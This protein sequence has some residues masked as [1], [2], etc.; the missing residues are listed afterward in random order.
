MTTLTLHPDTHAPA[1]ASLPRITGPARLLLVEDDPFN[2]M[3]G[4]ALLQAL[5]HAVDTAA[6]G[7]QAVALCLARDY[8][9]VLM[10]CIMPV[11][12]GRDATRRLREAGFT[13]PVIALTGASTER[14]LQ[15]CLAAGMNDCLTKPI[16]RARLAAMVGLWLDESRPAAALAAL[17]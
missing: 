9:L 16:D 1:R 7:E 17:N 2:Q 10:D 13:R 8:D 14:E 12:D 15:E 11:L 5:G 4:C 3:V 6:D